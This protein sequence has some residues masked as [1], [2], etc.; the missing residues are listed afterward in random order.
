MVALLPNSGHDIADMG[1]L[2][3]SFV[4]VGDAIG[5]KDSPQ[6]GHWQASCHGPR[7]FKSIV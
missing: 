3:P 4:A 7:D 5:A 1:W 6:T 2:E